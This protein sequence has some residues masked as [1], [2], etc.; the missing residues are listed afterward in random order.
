MCIRD[1]NISV[2]F[3]RRGEVSIHGNQVLLVDQKGRLARRYEILLPSQSDLKADLRALYEEVAT[4]G[5]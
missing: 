1:R 2:N 4:L 3:D 5:R